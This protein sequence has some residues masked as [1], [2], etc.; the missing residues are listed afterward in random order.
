MTIRTVLRAGLTGPGGGE[1]MGTHA[2]SDA[3]AAVCVG[4]GAG[5]GELP[6]RGQV[7][8]DT[9]A[10][11]AARTRHNRSPV[12]TP[13][14]RRARLRAAGRDAGSGT[15]LMVGSVGVLAIVLAGAMLLGAAILASGRARSAADLAALAG[16]TQTIAGAGGA[17]AC[18]STQG[19]ATLNG[20]RLIDCRVSGQFIALTVAVRPASGLVGRAV[21]SA[22]AGPGPPGAPSRGG[23]RVIG[24]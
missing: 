9:T 6:V 22:R 11:A 14:A 8:D 7:V 24:H 1:G 16:A 10:Y 15:V 5:A 20:A 3:G 17:A 2:G 13:L 19:V 18:Q 21:A 4:P 23:V 12:A